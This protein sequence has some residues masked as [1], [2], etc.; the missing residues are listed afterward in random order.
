MLISAGKAEPNSL[1]GRI[2]RVPHGAL[3]ITPDIETEIASG[4]YKKIHS[5]VVCLTYTK[6]FLSPCPPNIIYEIA[7]T[8][9]SD[10]LPCGTFGE[11]H[12]NKK[13]SDAALDFYVGL[14]NGPSRMENK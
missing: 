5:V 6:G 10:F 7:V 12:E 4:G 8:V 1:W 13:D 14:M 2:Q 3:R 11:I 9:G